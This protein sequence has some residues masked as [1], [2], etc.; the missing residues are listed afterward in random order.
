MGRQG[1]LWVPL[2]KD[3]HLVEPE[4]RVFSVV[5]ISIWNIPSRY[6][7]PLHPV[8]FLKGT[9]N[10]VLSVDLEIPSVDGANK[11]LICLF[12]CCHRVVEVL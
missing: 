9:K 4:K 7:W 12:C 8:A 11:W 1:A 5:A 3:V 2:I 10:V 6:D